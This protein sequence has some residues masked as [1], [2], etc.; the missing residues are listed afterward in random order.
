MRK[1]RTDRNLLQAELA[2]RLDIS[3]SYLSQLENDDRP[4]TAKLAERLARLFPIDWQDFATD[5]TEDLA[6]ALREA[7]SDPAYGQPFATDS[8]AKLA[9]QQPEFARRFVE[10]HERFQ[11]AN[12]RLEMVDEAFSADNSTGSRLPWEEV[13]DWFHFADNYIDPLDRSAE[14]LAQTFRSNGGRISLHALQGHLADQHG[15]GVV[16]RQSESLRAYDLDTQTLVV[17]SEQS[18]TGIRFQLAYQIAAMT[19]GETIEG[20]VTDADLRSATARE[21]LKVGLANYAAGAVLMPYEEFRRAARE[22]RHDVDRLA[23]QFQ[24]SFEQTCHRLS[25]LQRQGSRGVPVFFCRVD[26]AGNITKRHSATRLQ[27]ARFGGACPLWIVHEA[28]AIPDRILVQL[29]ETPD[30]IRY[31]SMAKGIVKPSGRF[32]RM[33]RRYALALGFE[34]QHASE[35]IYADTIDPQSNVGVTPI[36]V[37]CRICPRADCEQRAFPPSDQEI[38]I[39]PANRGIV[40]YRLQ[41]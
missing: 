10:L 16:L 32:D 31:V 15:V 22:V 24:T 18:A 17:D 40:P 38:R 28:V 36:G 3:A 41:T 6:N 29:A 1:I 8:L 19:L 37:S 7:V 2:K 30:G 27:F 4:L 25:T 21:L 14:R 9:E 33:P 13:R 39:D 12:Q 20:I 5:K 23:N 26:M 34:V 35:F 11:Q